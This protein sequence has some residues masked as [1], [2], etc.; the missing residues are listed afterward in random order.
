MTVLW[1][2]VPSKLHLS[3]VP[4]LYVPTVPVSGALVS[5]AWLEQGKSRQQLPSGL[6]C[7]N[8][9]NGIKEWHRCPRAY[10]QSI[11]IY[12]S[13]PRAMKVRYCNFLPMA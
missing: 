2:F 4:S 5:L 1:K 8:F 6:I 3:P 9:L 11:Q 12:D 7:Y 10:L 13:L